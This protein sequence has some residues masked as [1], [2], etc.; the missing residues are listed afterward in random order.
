MLKAAA[1]IGSSAGWESLRTCAGWVMSASMAGFTEGTVGPRKVQ[2]SLVVMACRSK[3]HGR[4]EVDGADGEGK[5]RRS[6]PTSSAALYAARVK[7]EGIVGWLRPHVSG[8]GRR[9]VAEAMPLALGPSGRPPRQPE[10]IVE[11]ADG[12]IQVARRPSPLR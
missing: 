7:T 1:S 2:F 9:T 12:G 3:A 10:R 5:E 4:L 11:M 6:S 8:V